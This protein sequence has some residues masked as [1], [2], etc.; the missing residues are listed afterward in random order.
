MMK[1][2]KYLECCVDCVESAIAAEQGGADR[3]ELCANLLIGGTT[4]E[5]PLLRAI[6]EQVSVPVNVLLRPR[7]GDFCYTNFEFQCLL[8]N[9]KL[10]RQAGADGIVVGALKP[11]GSLDKEKMQRLLQAADTLPVTLH[12]AFDV[13]RDPWEALEQ[14]IQWGVTTILTSGQKNSAAEGSTLLAQLVEKA[15]GKVEIMVGSGVSSK[16]IAQLDSQIHANWYHASCKEVI[17]S[18]M[19]FRREAVTMGLPVCSEYELWRTSRQ[20]VKKVKQ[21][22][23][24]LGEE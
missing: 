16:N 8:E 20:E 22:L 24:G 1:Q 14:C 13:C 9:V 21:A 18:P 2:N 6:K 3:L 19:F 5:L 23:M 11:D 4:P 10:F 12:R 17:Q 15:Q 7:F